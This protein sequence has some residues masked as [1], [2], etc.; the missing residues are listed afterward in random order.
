MF[1][2]ISFGLGQESNQ[3]RFEPEVSLGKE[4]APEKIGDDRTDRGVVRLGKVRVP[5]HV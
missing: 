5:F 2:E 1:D 4:K 3:M